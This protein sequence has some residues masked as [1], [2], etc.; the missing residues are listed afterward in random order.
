MDRPAEPLWHNLA[1]PLLD[2]SVG[3]LRYILRAWPLAMA[4]TVAIALVLSIVFQLLG[5]DLFLGEDPMAPLRAM[6]PPL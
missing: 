1:W 4:P 3:P 5:H 2:T 6:S